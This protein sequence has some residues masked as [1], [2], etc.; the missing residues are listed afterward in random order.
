M[1]GQEVGGGRRVV[2]RQPRTRDGSGRGSKKLT[3]V[4][5]ESDSSARRPT[6]PLPETTDLPEA[7]RRREA[8]VNLRGRFNEGA[9]TARA[10]VK[11]RSYL[12][13]L[14]LANRKAPERKPA[15]TP[16]APA[17][18]PR[19]AEPIEATADADFE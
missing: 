12:I 4:E 13:R 1:E 5:E 17:T 18:P 19:P 8:L 11:K 7:A 6:S 3:V 16:A 15:T 2:R 9:T 14:G 10:V